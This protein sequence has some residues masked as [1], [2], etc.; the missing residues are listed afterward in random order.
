MSTQAARA[1]ATSRRRRRQASGTVTVT[2]LATVCEPRFVQP[3]RQ[4]PRFV[5]IWLCPVNITEPDPEDQVMLCGV[6]LESPVVV[7]CK[8]PLGQ[9]MTQ[10]TAAPLSESRYDIEPSSPWSTIL[11]IFI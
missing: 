1:A 9:E 2:T 7:S 4:Q 10:P 3:N 5:L 11:S 6:L 8:P